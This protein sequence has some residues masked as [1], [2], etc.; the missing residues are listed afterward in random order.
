MITQGIH[1]ILGEGTEHID[2]QDLLDLSDRRFQGKFIIGEGTQE[3][4][5][6]T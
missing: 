6:Y 5:I 1:F 4:G 3:L 2:P